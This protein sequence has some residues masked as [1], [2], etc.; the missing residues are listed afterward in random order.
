[1]ILHSFA[2]ANLLENS[3]AD[4]DIGLPIFDS[5][6]TSQSIGEQAM[7]L[8][9]PSRTSKP[10][11]Y[12]RDYHCNLRFSQEQIGSSATKYPLHS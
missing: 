5:S 4:N 12:L 7:A 1:M 10:S 2:Y 8:R 9:R 3:L 6:L 11:S